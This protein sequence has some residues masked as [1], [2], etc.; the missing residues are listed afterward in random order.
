MDIDI[1]GLLQGG[2]LM[3]ALGVLIWRM[4][5]D[6]SANEKRTAADKSLAIALASL[7]REPING[8][9]LAAEF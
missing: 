3:T 6:A 4:N 7:G 1:A 8:I 5:R 9:S 2:G